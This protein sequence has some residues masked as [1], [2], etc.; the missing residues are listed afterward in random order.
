[1]EDSLALGSI[2]G[3]Q[4]TNQ[5]CCPTYFREQRLLKDSRYYKICSVVKLTKTQSARLACF[6]L[7]HPLWA[8]LSCMQKVNR[9]EQIVTILC[10]PEMMLQVAMGQQVAGL[11]SNKCFASTKFVSTCYITDVKTPTE[12]YSF[13]VTRHKYFKFHITVTITPNII[14]RFQLTNHTFVVKNTL[15]ESWKIHYLDTKALT[16]HTYR[17]GCSG[18]RAGISWHEPRAGLPL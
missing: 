15:Q 16:N 5:F 8:A 17:N 4:Q 11:L 13:P 1:M 2:M 10:R 14:H 3:C 6:M 7:L 18:T 9:R 12:D